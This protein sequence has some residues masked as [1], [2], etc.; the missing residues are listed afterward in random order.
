MEKSI[1]A[2][3]AVTLTYTM[4]TRL[5]DGTVKERPEETFEFIYGV[6]SQVPSLEA[7]LEGATEGDA[8]TVEI[9]SS[10]L[11]GE[12]DPALVREIPKEGLI[13]QRIKEGRY[14]RQMKKGC[15]VSFKVLEI[16][17]D[18]LLVDLNP[19]LAG[20]SAVVDLRIRSVRQATPEEINAAY[21]AQ[22]KRTIGCG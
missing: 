2:D 5:E 14:Y 13:K 11:F 1:D 17:D 6:E 12:R 21:D 4:K 15:L 7:T 19:P 3:C 10:E 16:R 8:L 20:I 22:V 18:S 9:P